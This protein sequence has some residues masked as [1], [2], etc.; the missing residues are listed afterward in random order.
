MRESQLEREIARRIVVA[1]LKAGYQIAV[2]DDSIE[3]LEYFT[4]ARACKA[5]AE[6]ESTFHIWLTKDKE[7]VPPF[8]AWVMLVP[9]NGPSF[10]SDY[11]VNLESMLAPINEFCDVWEED[12][13]IHYTKRSK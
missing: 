13:E 1:A 3:D 10:I 2:G 8:D 11:S 5:I 12:T 7:T 9:G 4:D 6:Q